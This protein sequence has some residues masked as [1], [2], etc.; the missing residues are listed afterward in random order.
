MYNLRAINNSI[1]PDPQ[2]RDTWIVVHPEFCKGKWCSETKP[3]V[4]AFESPAYEKGVQCHPRQRAFGPRKLSTSRIEDLFRG[5]PAATSGLNE[6]WGSS[7]GCSHGL[8]R[9]QSLPGWNR[10]VQ[11]APRQP[12][13]RVKEAMRR[14]TSWQA[15]GPV[16]EALL[17]AGFSP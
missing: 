1:T 13:A 5:Q 15:V 3:N 4:G 8:R 16:G 10:K 9:S 17:G 11:P 14:P 12:A 6:S 2:C 7:G